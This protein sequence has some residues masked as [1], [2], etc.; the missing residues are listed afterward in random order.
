[1]LPKP[2]QVGHAPNGLLNEKRRGCGSAGDAAHAAVEALGKLVQSL[3]DVRRANCSTTLR[4]RPAIGGFDGVGETLAVVP[5]P[6]SHAVDHDLRIGAFTKPFTST[7]SK[8]LRATIDEETAK[9]RRRSDSMADTTAAA[10]LPAV[11]DTG[12]PL[13]PSSP[14]R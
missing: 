1:M 8:R 13:S 3:P 5:P 12:D 9:P 10:L 7:S 11:A 4:R 2:W 14:A 6:I